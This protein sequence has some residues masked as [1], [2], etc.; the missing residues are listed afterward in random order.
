MKHINIKDI[1]VYADITGGVTTEHWNI[2]QHSHQEK[3][4]RFKK[5]KKYEVY[6]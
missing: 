2:A 5:Q 4:E 1:K 6:L 3:L